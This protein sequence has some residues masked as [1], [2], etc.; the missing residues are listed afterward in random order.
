[1]P[2]TGLAGEG[3]KEE[4]S[5]GGRGKE[6]R[7]DG[8][9]QRT[10]ALLL[11]SPRAFLLTPATLLTPEVDM[12]APEALA[13]SVPAADPPVAPVRDDDEGLRE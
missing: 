3:K 6:R 1:M 11:T 9:K 12:S 10:F 5:N 2:P 8:T 4:A 7:K 13:L